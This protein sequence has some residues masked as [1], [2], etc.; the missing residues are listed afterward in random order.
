MLSVIMQSVIGLISIR[1]CV[2]KQ[3]VTMLNVILLCVIWLTIMAPLKECFSKSGL[4]RR[5][6]TEKN[7][8]A[9]Y[10]AVKSFYSIDGFQTFLVIYQSQIM[11]R[12]C[13]LNI[14]ILRVIYQSCSSAQT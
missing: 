13:L 6:P 12:R 5:G 14:S 4:L 9:Y 11:V 10:F 3:C 2:I 8:L 7:T 1:L